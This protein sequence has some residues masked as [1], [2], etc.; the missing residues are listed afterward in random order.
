MYS[1]EVDLILEAVGPLQ[2]ADGPGGAVG[3]VPG[4]GDGVE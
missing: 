1:P 4:V 2:V 3:K